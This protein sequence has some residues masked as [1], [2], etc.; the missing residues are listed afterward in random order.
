MFIFGLRLAHLFE[1]Q[2]RDQMKKK[3]TKE[4]KSYSHKVAESYQRRVGL[5][6]DLRVRDRHDRTRVHA[7]QPPPPTPTSKKLHLDKRAGALADQEGRDDDLLSTSQIAEW[8]GVCESWVMNGRVYHY[9][10]PFVRVSGKL[11]RYRRGD[12]RAWL[13]QRLHKSTREYSR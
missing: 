5:E 10:P 7:A 9:G 1:R 6:S 12:V 8:F 3:S 2:A 4:V 11:I 13:L